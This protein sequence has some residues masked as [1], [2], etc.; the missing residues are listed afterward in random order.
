MRRLVQLAIVA[1]LLPAAATT[2]AAQG[3]IA[4]RVA[5]ARDGVVRMSYP[6]RPGACGHGGDMVRYGRAMWARSFTGW[7]STDSRCETGPVRVALTV[8]DGRPI[9]VTTA[10]GGEWRETG[11]RIT[12]LGTVP[13]GEAAAYFLSIVPQLE[14]SR[15]R[16]RILLPAMLAADAPVMPALIALARS[17]ARA[18][19]TRSHAITWLGLFGGDT[20]SR[21]LRRMIEDAGEPM[22][23]RKQAIFALA[24]GVDPDPADFT[25][26]RELFGR[27]GSESL[28]ESVLHAMTQDDRGGS[29]WLLRIARNP[30]ERLAT[31]KTALFWAAQ[32]EGTRTEDLVTVYGEARPQGLREH[33]IFVLSQRGDEQALSA[34]MAIAKGDADTRMRGR[35]LFW[36][37]QKNDPRVTKMIADL[38]TAP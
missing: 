31:R 36:L 18:A 1:S 22:G 16:D 14:Q 37:A 20:A 21:E 13:S 19:S 33:A 24:H 4:A 8:A 9:G 7:G 17:D 34:L 15:D 25:Y 29:A 26:L 28:R 11:A 5:A 12:D 6:S 35:A 32:A 30:E 38:V 23:V 2:S 3:S 10:I 27:A